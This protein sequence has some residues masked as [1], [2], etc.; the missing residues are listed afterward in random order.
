MA[1][2]VHACVWPMRKRDREDR[3]KGKG[4]KKVNAPSSLSGGFEPK[5]REDAKGVPYHPIS[6][7]AFGHFLARTR[8]TAREGGDAPGRNAAIIPRSPAGTQ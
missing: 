4:G 3:T 6:T 1:C 8:P 7:L 5:I 2:D